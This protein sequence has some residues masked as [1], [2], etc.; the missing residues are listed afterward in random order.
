[1]KSKF[2]VLAAATLATTLAAILLA[3]PVAAGPAPLSYG[4]H[5]AQAAAALG[6]TDAQKSAL[7]DAIASEKDAILASG[8]AEESARVAL[9]AAIQA[10]PFDEAGI[11]EAFAPVAS[12]NADV[13]ALR[14]RLYAKC[15]AILTREQAMKASFLLTLATERIGETLHEAITW[16]AK[17]PSALPRFARL[18]LSSEQRKQVDAVFAAHQPEIAGLLAQEKSA[19]TALLAA[20][21][22]TSADEAGAR[23]ASAKVSALD[24]SLSRLRGEVHEEISGILTQAQSAKLTKAH[25][26]VRDLLVSRADALLRLVDALL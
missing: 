2:V 21:R 14:A 24:L 8:Q 16:A 18:G 15:F 10:S 13:A 22:R 17:D 4:S 25:D 20:I 3:F 6:L 26:A 19:R 11:E 9:D 5:L 7:R 1:M 12:A 23:A